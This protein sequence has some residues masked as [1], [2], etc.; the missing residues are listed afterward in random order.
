MARNATTMTEMTTPSDDDQPITDLFV[1]T[2]HPA[3]HLS[4][5]MRNKEELLEQCSG[6]VLSDTCRAKCV[7]TS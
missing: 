7:A 6:Y 4:N 1:Q 5:M 3:Y 2:G